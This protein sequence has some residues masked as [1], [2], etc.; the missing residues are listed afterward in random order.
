M[1]RFLLQ[2]RTI[3]LKNVKQVK[4]IS[5]SIFLLSVNV[6]VFTR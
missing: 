5:N 3:S 6:P 4:K 1:N 2:F